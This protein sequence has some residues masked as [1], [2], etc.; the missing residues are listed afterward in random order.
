M[1]DFDVIS[2]VAVA[3][4][5]KLR[6]KAPDESYTI[7]I[8]DKNTKSG[9][10]N[11]ILSVQVIYDSEN[12]VE[13]KDI[14]EAF[15][16]N[17]LHVLCFLTGSRLK[18]KNINCIINLEANDGMYECHQYRTDPDI[19]IPHRIL[20]DDLLNSVKLLTTNPLRKMG[21]R[22]IDLYNMGVNALYSDEQYTFFW[23]ALET[24]SIALKSDEPVNIECPDCSDN[25]FCKKC[26]DYPKRKPF[27]KNAI[28]SL[29]DRVHKGKGH[30]ELVAVLFEF[31]NTIFHGRSVNKC[32][33]N[34]SIK[35]QKVV[36]ILGG[37]V[38]CALWQMVKLPEGQWRIPMTQPNTYAHF[39][40]Q[41][42]AKLG[43]S[44]IGNIS[45]EP[46]IEDFGSVQMTVEVRE[47]PV[48]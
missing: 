38:F 11:P 14:G 48:T 20:N 33:K 44:K 39:E 45:T 12:G 13:S 30:D 25:L 15:L 19:N 18:I 42:V 27:D 17:F 22:A 6:F 32:E 31:R 7:H 4:D 24:L 36:D 40:V 9:T 26:D 28:T 34:H 16:R 37:I 2:H 29:L 35:I 43:I 8:K 46:E 41:S 21:D 47:G 10:E 1:A 5:K 3:T 23:L